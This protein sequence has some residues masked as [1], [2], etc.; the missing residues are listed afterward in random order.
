MVLKKNT[1]A[2]KNKLIFILYSIFFYFSLVLNLQS[3]NNL[4]GNY[5]DIKILDKISS[6]NRI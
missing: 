1:L 5:T 3:Q 6:K 2:G 4:E